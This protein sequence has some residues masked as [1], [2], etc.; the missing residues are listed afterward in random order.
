MEIMKCDQVMP[1]VVATCP[2]RGAF[3]RTLLAPFYTLTS[4]DWNA[5]S[6]NVALAM[7]PVISVISP[8]LTSHRIVHSLSL[9]VL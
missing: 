7:S 6:S 5:Q 1:D 4:E 2:S 3:L 9:I 8:K